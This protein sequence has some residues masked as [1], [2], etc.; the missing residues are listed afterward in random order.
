MHWDFGKSLSQ[1]LN[2]TRPPPDPV[3]CGGRRPT[4]CSG[5]HS[6]GG[7]YSRQCKHGMRRSVSDCFPTRPSSRTHELCVP[8]DESASTT[9][10]PP[11]GSCLKLYRQ[12]PMC[13]DSALHKTPLYHNLNHMLTRL[14]D[15]SARQDP[16]MNLPDRHFYIMFAC[17]LTSPCTLLAMKPH[18]CPLDDV[19]DG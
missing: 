14:L 5:Y 18:G 8:P 19:V 1:G 15:A 17:W 10:Q 6:A 11:S 2:A 13:S 7:V 12:Q 16:P 3:Y 9:R 4:L